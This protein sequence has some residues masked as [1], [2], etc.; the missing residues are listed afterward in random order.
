[1]AAGPGR[2]V[3]EAAGTGTGAGG[4]LAPLP[5][6]RF[7]GGL[8]VKLL[9]LALLNALTLWG[10]QEMVSHQKHGWAVLAAI[11][12]VLLDAIYLSQRRF[13]PGKYLYP[14]TLLL[15]VFAMSSLLDNIAGLDKQRLSA[16][17]TRDYE[18]RYQLFLALAALCLIAATAIPDAK[19]NTE[20]A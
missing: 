16:A 5:S 11:A 10:I 18:E 20:R 14:G 9:V 19:R 7:T 6:T 2:L 3:G 13:V 17:T 8:I 12:L 15:L 4:G 1:M